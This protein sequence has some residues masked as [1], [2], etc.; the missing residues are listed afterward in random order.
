MMTGVIGD[1]LQTEG[2]ANF[3]LLKSVVVAVTAGLL[4]KIPVIL[5]IKALIV[6]LILVPF[7]LFVLS[8]PFILPIVLLFTPLWTKLKETFIG[9][10]TPTPAVVVMMDNATNTASAKG[11]EVNGGGNVLVALMESDR[12]LEK[13]ACLVGSRDSHSPLMK[14]V[15]W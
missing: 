14:P 8:L 6:K 4:A 5:A 1:I 12:C 11:R 2:F 15:S 10:A 9:T 13:L 7:G 3:G